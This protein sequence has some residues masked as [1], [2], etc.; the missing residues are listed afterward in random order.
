MGKFNLDD[1]AELSYFMA[2]NIPMNGAQRGR[3]GC[4]LMLR[5]GPSMIFISQPGEHIYCGLDKD[6]ERER[7]G[8]ASSRAPDKMVT[9]NQSEPLTGMMYYKSSNSCR[10][11]MIEY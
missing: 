4:S 6:G 8:S 7:K 10:C 3:E 1:M 9:A 2:F 5:K 11:L